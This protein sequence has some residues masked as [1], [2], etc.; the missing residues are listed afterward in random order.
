[1]GSVFWLCFDLLVLPVNAFFL[2]TQN[3]GSRLFGDGLNLF[4]GDRYLHGQGDRCDKCF[5]MFL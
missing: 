1:M 3:A 4:S 2:S 5:F